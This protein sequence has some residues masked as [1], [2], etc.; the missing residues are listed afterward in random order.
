MST[1]SLGGIPVP[2]ACRATEASEFEIERPM[3]AKVNNEVDEQVGP[4][5]DQ[6][7]GDQKIFSL[8]LEIPDAPL[9]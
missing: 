2:H 6:G 3:G 8:H 4:L 5:L 9:V 1:L 7:H